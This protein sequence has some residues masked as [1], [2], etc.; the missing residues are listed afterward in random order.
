MRVY[1]NDEERQIHVYDRETG[2][3]YAKS[4]LCSQDRMSTD[5][6]GEFCLS[7][8]EYTGWVKLLEKLQESEDIR[9]SLKEKVD[10]EELKNYLYEETKYVTHTKETI[11]MENI[12]LK[13]VQEALAAHNN[14]WLAENGFTK[15]IQE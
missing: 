3:D 7:E 14:A 12:C 6:Y 13:E 4:V 1:V 2:Q 11:D 10:G 5:E 9:F 15:T 8:E